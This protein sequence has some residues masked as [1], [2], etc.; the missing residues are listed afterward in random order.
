MG[1][2]VQDR[3][4][5]QSGGRNGSPEDIA[6]V[7]VFAL[8]DDAAWINGTDIGVDGGGEVAIAFDLLDKP[9]EKAAETFFGHS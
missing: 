6:R 2:E 9:P 8:S 1:A 5:D 3:L 7:I 4:K